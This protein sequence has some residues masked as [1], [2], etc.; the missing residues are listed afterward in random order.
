MDQEFQ[1]YQNRGKFKQA[2]LNEV[3]LK[4]V[5]ISRFSRHTGINE[6]TLGLIFKDKQALSLDKLDIITEALSFPPCH[7]YKDYINE[8]F[9]NGHVHY[10]RA[11]EFIVH[12]YLLNQVELAEEMKSYLIE[13]TSK[14]QVNQT[15]MEIAE[16]LFLIGKTDV[17]EPFY[18]YIIQGEETLSE[19]LAIAVLR[20]YTIVRLR[21]N[22]EQTR[23]YLYKLIDMV[24]NLPTNSELIFHDNHKVHLKYQCQAYFL[25]VKY[26]NSR[27]DWEQVYYYASK[28]GAISVGDPYYHPSSIIYKI[29]SLRERGHLNEALILNQEIS[30]FGSTYERLS[31]GNQRLIEVENGNQDVIPAVLEWIENDDEMKLFLPIMLECYVKNENYIDGLHMYQSYKHLFDEPFHSV[32]LLHQRRKSRLFLSAAELFFKLGNQEDACIYLAEAIELSLESK[33]LSRF[34]KCMLLF[35]MNIHM[36]RQSELNLIQAS[37]KRGEIQYG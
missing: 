15:I 17:T 5:S 11:S 32:M 3:R 4:Y 26:F 35:S 13:D 2:L 33:N 8:C 1:R 23:Q 9:I 24:G 19:K 21:K 20:K 12:C 10:G 28:L 30:N 29:S 14:R 37:I 31:I 6:R 16:Q 25:I 18:D 27:E 34:Q 7:F 36:I 22:V